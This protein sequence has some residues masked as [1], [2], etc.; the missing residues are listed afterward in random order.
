MCRSY[1]CAQQNLVISSGPG[2]SLP[3]TQ[4][5]IFRAKCTN[6]EYEIGIHRKT[7]KVWFKAGDN[8]LFDITQT[9]L[10]K[11]LGEHTLYGRTALSCLP[12]SVNV[13]FFGYRI[14]RG[15][16]SQPIMFTAFIGLDGHVEGGEVQAT[17]ELMVTSHR[18]D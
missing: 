3:A 10:G 7:Q 5:I 4:D 12:D 16:A 9:S 14:A 2:P 6:I 11:T 18:M 15:L 1:L 8:S 13:Q 17:D